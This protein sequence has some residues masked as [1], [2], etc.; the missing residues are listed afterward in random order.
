VHV[1]VVVEGLHVS[2]FVSTQVTVTVMGSQFWQ[3]LLGISPPLFGAPVCDPGTT[4][5]AGVEV[6]FV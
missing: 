1:V 5:S 6:E 2:V 4:A 3:P